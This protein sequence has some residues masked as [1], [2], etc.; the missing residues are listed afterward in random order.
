ME[1][2]RRT[3]LIGLGSLLVTPAIVRASSLMPISTNLMR[4]GAADALAS[5]MIYQANIIH[6]GVDRFVPLEMTTTSGHIIIA[7]K[8][9]PFNGSQLLLTD[10][11]EIIDTHDPVSN[12]DYLHRV[13][14]YCHNLAGAEQRALSLCIDIHKDKKIKSFSRTFLVYRF[15]PFVITG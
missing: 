1:H 10:K 6:L 13:S 4:F 2:R 9:S 12:I 15:S 7:A 8:T 11:G 5:K 14:T 3:F